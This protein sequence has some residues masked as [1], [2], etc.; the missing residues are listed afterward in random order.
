MITDLTLTPWR[1][2]V[3]KSSLV[4]IP[5]FLPNYLLIFE[6]KTANLIHGFQPAG[7]TLGAI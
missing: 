4:E 2:I 7:H 1:E 3:I 6:P 5:K